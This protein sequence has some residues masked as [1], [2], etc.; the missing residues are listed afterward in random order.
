[1][2]KTA[3]NWLA[4]AD[5]DLQTAAATLKSQRYLYVVF[6]C[7]L[8]MEKTLKATYAEAL[9]DTPPRTHDLLFLVRALSLTVPKTH[10]DFIGIINN[11]S[12]PTRYPEDLSRLV[13]Q[14]PCRVATS[15]LART[16]RVIKWL[17]KDPRLTER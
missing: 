7:H 2:K 1:M 16:T 5:Y 17:R 4:T 3:A 15:Y 14:Y 6:M 10:L 11:A 9:P 13:S 8:A 12:I